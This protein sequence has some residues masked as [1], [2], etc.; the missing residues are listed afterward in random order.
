MHQGQAHVGEAVVHI[1]PFVEEHD[2]DGHQQVE[3]EPGGDAPIAPHSL[4]QRGHDPHGAGALPPPRRTPGLPSAALALFLRVRAPAAAGLSF[5][6]ASGSRA[7]NSR[8]HM[9]CHRPASPRRRGSTSRAPRPLPR[10]SGR[11][12]FRPQLGAELRLPCA[13]AL[14]SWCAKLLSSFSVPP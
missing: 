13:G 7:S 2:A 10:D 4:R 3:K 5:W 1:D 6:P 14:G 9:L 8:V 11:R 12:R